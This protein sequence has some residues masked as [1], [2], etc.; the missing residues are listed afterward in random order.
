MTAKQAG[1][2]MYDGDDQSFIAACRNAEV[3]ATYRQYRKWCRGVG[4]ARRANDARAS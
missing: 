1:V 4:S 2:R 3:K